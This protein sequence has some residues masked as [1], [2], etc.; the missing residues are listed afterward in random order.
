MYSILHPKLNLLTGDITL[1]PL[2][3][4]LPNSVPPHFGHSLMFVI[5]ITLSKKINPPQCQ[6]LAAFHPSFPVNDSYIFEQLR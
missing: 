4:P 3:F 1:Y 2:C 5:S 6:V